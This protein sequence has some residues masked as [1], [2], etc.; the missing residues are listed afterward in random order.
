MAAKK[1]K[2]STKKKRTK[3][4]AT[5]RASTSKPKQRKSEFE[6]PAFES[7]W[8]SLRKGDAFVRTKTRDESTNT[9]WMIEVFYEAGAEARSFVVV[10][11]DRSKLRFVVT[12]PNGTTRRVDY[13]WDDVSFD[14]GI[15][16]IESED[17]RIIRPGFG[18]EKVK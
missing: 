12:L 7:S 4:A 18:W 6:L 17:R 15:D 11:K 1:K 5:K 9:S 16:S 13:S 10:G 14:S 3:V 8:K 2:A